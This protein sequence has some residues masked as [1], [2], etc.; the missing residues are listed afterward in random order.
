MA[1]T[2]KAL[3][4]TRSANQPAN[5]AHTA[6]AKA[7][8]VI[9]NGTKRSARGSMGPNSAPNLGRMGVT[10]TAPHD[11]QAAAQHQHQP[12]TPTGLAGP[13]GRR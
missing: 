6:I 10:I 3:R 11:R 7:G 1:I 8:P 13:A 4:P 5:G 12:F 2:S 9:A